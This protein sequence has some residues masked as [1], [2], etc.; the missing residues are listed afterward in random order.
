MTRA[1]PD[2]RAGYPNGAY[3]VC[4]LGTYLRHLAVCKTAGRFVIGDLI[5]AGSASLLSCLQY[6]LLSAG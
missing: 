1:C 2:H 5:S 4:E 3:P 6:L